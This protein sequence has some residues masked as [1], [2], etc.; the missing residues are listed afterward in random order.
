MDSLAVTDNLRAGLLTLLEKKSIKESNSP[1]RDRNRELIS[2]LFRKREDLK[3][4][5]GFLEALKKTDA[6][7]AIMA[8]AILKTYKYGIGATALEKVTYTTL[9]PIEETKYDLQ[10]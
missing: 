6:S 3:P 4:F 1:R 7:H 9:S 5:E 2:I 8:E 10:M